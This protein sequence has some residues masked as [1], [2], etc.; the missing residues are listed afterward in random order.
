MGFK[1]YQAINEA[2]KPTKT[3]A[4]KVA[5]LVKKTYG[6]GAVQDITIKDNYVAIIFKSKVSIDNVGVVFYNGFDWQ[7]SV[8][9][10][11]FNDGKVTGNTN[12]ATSLMYDPVSEYGKKQHNK[13]SNSIAVVARAMFGL[14]V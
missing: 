7:D 13:Y 4:K 5:G 1:A 12:D 10:G 14:K 8:D 6:L 9:M 11:I 3:E 2:K